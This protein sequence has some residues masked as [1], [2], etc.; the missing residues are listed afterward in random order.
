MCVCSRWMSTPL[1]L[2]SSKQLPL[3][4]TM[5]V[6]YMGCF[7]LKIL[8]VVVIGRLDLRVSA[9]LSKSCFGR[10]MFI[11]LTWSNQLCLNCANLFSSG[12]MSN[13][14]KISLFL[15]RSNK[16]RACLVN[17]IAA[18]I[19]PCA[20]RSRNQ[21][22]MMGWLKYIISKETVFELNLALSTFFARS[23]CQRDLTRRS[24]SLRR[25]GRRFESP[26][27]PE[28]L[29]SSVYHHHSFVTLSSMLCSLVTEKGHKNMCERNFLEFTYSLKLRPC[30]VKIYLRGCLLVTVG[31]ILS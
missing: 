12:A 26:L 5:L 1:G 15:L 31:T 9:G 2:D 29:S 24:W 11:C 30:S 14:S 4:V 19:N 20:S 21:I 3:R 10:L 17:S 16:L 25:W 28:C 13:F 23:Q 6:V 22:K 8:S 7:S 27:R 18:F